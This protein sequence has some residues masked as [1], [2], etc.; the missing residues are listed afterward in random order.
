M[1]I[2]YLGIIAALALLA[3]GCGPSS[4]DSGDV[5]QASGSSTSQ[6]NA[7]SEKEKEDGW[8]LLFDG[9]STRGWHAYLG[10]DSLGWEVKDGV[11]MT[12]GKQGDIVTDQDFEN[13]ELLVEWKIEEQGNSGIFYHVVEQPDYPRM[14][15]TGPEFQIIDDH[16][17]PQEL[18]ENQK[19][20]SNSDVKAASV[21][22]SNPPGNWNQ[23]RIRVDQGKVVFWLNGQQINDYDMESAEW[24]AMVAGSKFAPMDYA[25]VRSG[26]IGLQD[27][28]GPVAFRNIKIRPL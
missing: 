20:G 26:K 14:Y 10:S 24:Q 17:Y 23:T 6:H 2:K 19:T 11:L 16:N 7:L 18:M 1:Y 13:F 21:S 25:K 27:H 22:A 9:K 3:S 8:E 28:G 4:V 15:E 5:K 12:P